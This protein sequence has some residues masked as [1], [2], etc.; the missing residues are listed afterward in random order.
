[1]LRKIIR[2][3]L[4]IVGVV[5][6][7][8]GFVFV[9]AWRSPA[10]Y[11]V[12]GAKIIAEPPIIPFTEYGQIADHPRP[13]ILTDDH[14]GY[15]IFGATH[16]RDPQHPQIP[17]L[18]KEWLSLRPTVALVEGRL[19]F[20]LPGIMEPVGNLGEGGLVKALADED[21][22]PV[23]NWDL[24]KEALASKLNGQFRAEQIALAQILNPYF[25]QLRFGKPASPEKFIA[26]YLKRAK[27]VGEEQ[28]FKSAADVDLVWRKYFPD[29]KDWREVSD[30]YELPGYLSEMMAA[31]N[32]L[33]N[34][35]L[36]AAVKELLNKG[37]RVFAVC[38]S[39][40]A[41][42]VAPAFENMQ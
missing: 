29:G 10:Y 31:T 36:V 35:Q 30:E 6:V 14:K 41:A 9:F 39:S 8:L 24:S 11:I 2:I 20:L 7:L 18:K 26:E 42:C 23:Y 13:F 17:L 28:N 34:Q 4:W 19:D 1:M 37:E 32:D 16:T 21:D 33:R 38:G 40:Y 27:Y 22:V 3:L 5:V 15:V 25:S 12:D